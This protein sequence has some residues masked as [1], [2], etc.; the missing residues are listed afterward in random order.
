MVLGGYILKSDNSPLV[1]II[2]PCYNSEEHI[3][4]CIASVLDQNYDNLEL[5][6]VDDGSSDG[7]LA[8]LKKIEINECKVKVFTQKQSGA[9]VARNLGIKK[10]S[11]YYVKF[12]DSD[13]FLENGALS[14]QVEVANALDPHFIPYGYRK[15]LNEHGSKVVKETLNSDEQLCELINKNIT[16]TLPLHKRSTLLSM[17]MFDERLNFRQEWDLHL[18]LAKSGFE[19]YYHDDCIFTQYIHQSE[20]RIS[21]RKL[22]INKE[23]NNLNLI[24]S[25]LIS[26]SN[27]CLKKPWAFKYWTLGRQFVKEKMYA[28][29]KL[30]FDLSKAISPKGYMKLQPLAYRIGCFIFGAILTEK[31]IFIFKKFF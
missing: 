28:E 5:I 22:D 2:I 18:R 21:A 13:D 29:A 3:E 15:V 12:L 8:K 14:A 19:F 24:R 17:G 1:S 31:L 30:L 26:P 20:D 4:V 23:L 6:V 27:L 10:S 9:C 11:G 7:S 16:I 25:K